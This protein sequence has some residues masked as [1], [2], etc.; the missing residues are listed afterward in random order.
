M[1]VGTPLLITQVLGMSDT[2]YGFTQGALALGGLC[3]G[4]LTAIVS[5][6]LKLQKSYVLLLVCS[7]A[8]AVMGISLFLNMPAIVSYWVITLMSFAAMGAS[9]LF[10]V[11]IYTMV[12]TQTPPQLVGK[13]MAALISI[14]MCG[15]PIGQAIYGV[16]FDIFAMHTWV[17]LIGGAVAA[18]LISLYSRKIFGRLENSK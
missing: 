5:E 10:M 3:G 14:A 6:K 18:L 2:M 15:Q 17:V 13:I 7:A 4:V 11:Q 16:L 12:Q 9:T 8:V 1:I